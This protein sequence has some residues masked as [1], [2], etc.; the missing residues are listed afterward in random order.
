M[1]IIFRYS[2]KSI[3]DYILLKKK[4]PGARFPVPAANLK[5]ACYFDTAAIF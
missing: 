1:S 3:L 5:I 2:S 4:V